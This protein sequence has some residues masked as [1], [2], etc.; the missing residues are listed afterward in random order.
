MLRSLLTLFATDRPARPLFDAVVAA[1]RQPHWYRDGGVPDTVEG[2]FAMLATLAALVNLRLEAGGEAARRTAVSLAECFIDEMDGEVR[3]M[4]IGDPTIAKQVGA[5]VG[6][7]SSRVGRFR[8]L[9]SGDSDWAEEVAASLYRGRP[10]A[11][12]AAADHSLRAI[13]AFW[14]ALEQAEES[15]VIA[16]RWEER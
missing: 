6:A 13:R 9:V 15:A 12:R 11:D 14:A 2:R 7:V 4:G 3:Q 5:M 10:P 1:A 8:P 16:G